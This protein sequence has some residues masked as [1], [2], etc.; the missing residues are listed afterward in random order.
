[1]LQPIFR[2]LCAI[3]IS[4]E[5]DSSRTYMSFLKLETSGKIGLYND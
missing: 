3:A 1:L 2:L 5:T 4:I